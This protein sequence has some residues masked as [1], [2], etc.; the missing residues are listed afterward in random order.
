MITNLADDQRAT[1]Y[2]EM[3]NWNL[4]QAVNIVIETGGVPSHNNPPPEPNYA[5]FM[6]PDMNPPNIPL[7]PQYQ[8]YMEDNAPQNFNNNF[9][10]FPQMQQYTMPEFT[11]EEQTYYNV[12]LK[13]ADSGIMKKAKKMGGAILSTSN[14]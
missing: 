4:E 14:I 9:G 13:K 12:K 5:D 6:G 10:N 1:Q 11:P 8:G 7:E 2:M 3:C